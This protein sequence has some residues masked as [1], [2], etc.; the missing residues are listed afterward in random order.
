MH[1]V[2]D[3]LAADIESAAAGAPPAPVGVDHLLRQGRRSLLRRRAAL[4]AGTAAAALVVG[5]GA[6]ALAPAGTTASDTTDPAA[7]PAGDPL[8]PDTLA[9]YDADTGEL[10][11]APGWAVERRLDDPLTGPAAADFAVD[12]VD[13]SVG[14]VLTSGGETVWLIAWYG[15]EG[16]GDADAIAGTITTGPGEDYESFAVFLEITAAE[17]SDVR[18][19]EWGHTA[20]LLDTDGEVQVKPGWTVAERIDAPT[21]PG[22][23]AVDVTDGKRH[24][25]FVFEAGGGE[26]SDVAA[27]PA[28]PRT[29]DASY[30]DFQAWVDDVVGG[31]AANRTPD[32]GAR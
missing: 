9:R 1:D 8:P 11:I 26:I 30:A 32:E 17:A 28:D 12:R 13:D 15:T 10:T 21:G 22:S 24:Q 16:S 29:P 25:W 19:G 2:A 4:G 27:D 3:R 6:W 5:G 18:A 31:L 14:L 7:P 20:A 23:V